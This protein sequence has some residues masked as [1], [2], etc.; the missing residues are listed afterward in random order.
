MTEKRDSWHREIVDTIAKLYTTVLEEDVNT[1]DYYVIRATRF[2]GKVL[3]E[4]GNFDKE[5]ENILE[6]FVKPSMRDEMRD[7]LD[8]STIVQRLDGEE[9]ISTEYENDTERWFV[10]RFLPLRWDDDGNLTHVLYLAREITQEKQKEIL[11][12]NQMQEALA[13]AERANASKTNFLRRMSHDI[14]TPLNG[15]IGMLRIM[16]DHEGDPVKYREYM[17]KINRSSEYLLSIINNVL[18]IGK[19][20]TGEIEL[21]NRP[22][23]LGQVLLNTLP[24]VSSNASLNSVIFT[25]GREDTH[26]RHRYVIGSPVH[27]NR[28]LMNLASNAI[29]YNRSGGYIKVYCNELRSDNETATYEFVCEDSGQGMSEEFQKHAFDLYSREGKDTTTGFS[30]SGLGLSI[31]KRIVDKMGGTV[32]LSSKEDVGTTIKVVLSFMIDK[33]PDSTKL[34]KEEPMRLDLS[35]RRALLVEDNEINME[36]ATVILQGMGLE[37]TGATNGK[38]AVDTFLEAEDYAFDFIFMDIMMP[39]MDGLD[40]T[41]TIRE[42]PKADAKSVPIIAMTANAFTEDRQAC[43]DAGMNDHVGKPIDMNELTRVLWR[44]V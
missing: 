44:F 43:L 10:T 8:L 15:I 37:V 18:D 38:K 19:M 6:K 36:I 3:G 5:M 9:S 39:V 21:E 2:A 35:G 7:F 42:L 11:Y 23:D 40:A 4:S 14:R 20:E 12:M 34:G 33:D 22:F 28:I 1:H 31:V 26:I 32:E 30:G 41:R 27:V 16:D 24:I 29:K 17:D 25:G 13:E